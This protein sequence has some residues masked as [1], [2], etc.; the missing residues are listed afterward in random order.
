MKTENQIDKKKRLELEDSSACIQI[1][2]LCKSYNG[3]HVLTDLS[4]TLS[5]GKTYCLMAPSGTG[6]TTLFRILMELE[7]ADSGQIDG[8]DRLRIAAI[9][10]EDRLLEGYTAL[11]NL[12]FVTGNQYSNEELNHALLRL[13]PAE[14]LNKPV[15]E[16]SGGMKRRT[17]ILRAILAP[18]D[19]IIMDEPFTGL[20]ADTKLQVIEMIKEYTRGKLVLFSSHHPEDAELLSAEHISL[21]KS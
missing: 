1:R 11:E 17:A 5:M 13:L 10:Q 9:F 15:C 20:D 3:E 16:F 6:K 2:N 7:H 8:L 19:F 21:V 14:A 12:R 4:L 18:S